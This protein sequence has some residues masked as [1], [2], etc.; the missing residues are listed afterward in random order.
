MFREQSR[1][2]RTIATSRCDD[3]RAESHSATNV[4]QITNNIRKRR[5]RT[6]LPVRS[7]PDGNREG[8]TNSF[9][10]G[11]THLRAIISIRVASQ[12]PPELAV[13]MMTLASALVTKE[14]VT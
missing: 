9:R 13:R 8:L 12:K 11:P 14:G 2:K 7:N 3:N 10:N 5:L 1:Q 6:A 4:P